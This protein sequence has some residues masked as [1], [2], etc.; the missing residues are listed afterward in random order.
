MAKREIKK[1]SDMDF[2]IRF[3][4]SILKESP[5]FIE[6]LIALG[7][8]YTKRGDYHKGLAV[9]ERLLKLRSQDPAILYN[10]ACSYSLVG[11]IDRSLEAV[12][13]AV[14]Y[15]YNHFKYLMEDGDLKNLRQDERFKEMISEM[16]RKS[17][18]PR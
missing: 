4:E 1:Q 16:T 17:A 15:G 9:D 11:D 14:D 2:E 8:R 6:A 13:K 5:Y 7:D 18:N 10:L 3:F 12:K